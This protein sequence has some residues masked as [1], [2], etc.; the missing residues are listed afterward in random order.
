[1][2]LKMHDFMTT[3]HEFQKRMLPADTVFAAGLIPLLIGGMLFA[4]HAFTDGSNI[5]MLAAVAMLFVGMGGIVL[6]WALAIWLF[7]HNK[8]RRLTGYGCRRCGYAPR[9]ID[10]Y[11]GKPHP[12]PI[13]GQPQY[14]AA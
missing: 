2:K 10:I 11:T 6:L 5:N 14:D 3:H 13:C 9:A 1:M 4:I 7:R 12:C 8:R